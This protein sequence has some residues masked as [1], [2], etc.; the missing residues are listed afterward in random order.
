MSAGGFPVAAIARPIHRFAPLPGS[1]VGSCTAAWDE[2]Q[3]E[4]ARYSTARW[5]QAVAVAQQDRAVLVNELDGIH[6]LSV[7]GG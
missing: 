5:A 6:A 3:A 1:H 7:K 2:I 4:I